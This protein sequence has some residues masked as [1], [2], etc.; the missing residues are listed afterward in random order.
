MESERQRRQAAEWTVEHA[1][2]ELERATDQHATEVE[3]VSLAADRRIASMQ[4]DISR[5]ERALSSAT[6]LDRELRAQLSAA[7][8]RSRSATNSAESMEE[9]VCSTLH[10]HT[11]HSSQTPLSNSIAAPKGT[12]AGGKSPI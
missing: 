10:Y 9:Q 12:D 1:R 7:E 3:A 8:G 6:D 11:S 4:A 5:L 2:G